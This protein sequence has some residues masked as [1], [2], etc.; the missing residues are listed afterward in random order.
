MILSITSGNAVI[1]ALLKLKPM[2]KLC[3]VS[4]DWRFHIKIITLNLKFRMYMKD[5]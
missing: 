3:R 4:S 5:I 1:T 2:G